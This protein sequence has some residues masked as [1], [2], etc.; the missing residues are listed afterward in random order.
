MFSTPLRTTE[1]Q[2]D[3]D[4]GRRNPSVSRAGRK[5]CALA[6]AAAYG[7]VLGDVGVALKTSGEGGGVRI[8]PVWRQKFFVQ[9]GREE[10]AEES[11]GCRS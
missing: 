9:V 8:S 2:E 7:V 3:A 10:I 6:A 1:P 11:G 4:G 5:G